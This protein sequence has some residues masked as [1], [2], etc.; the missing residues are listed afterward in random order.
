MTV[1]MRGEGQSVDR[2]F[3]TGG[4]VTGRRKR[5][6]V[7][8]LEC[9]RGWT[10]V[11]RRDSRAEQ[12]WREDGGIGMRSSGRGKQTRS[13]APRSHGLLQ[14]RPGW[15]FCARTREVKLFRAGRGAQQQSRR[16]TQLS[17]RKVKRRRGGGLRHAAPGRRGHSS[18]K[19]EEDAI[20][21]NC[22]FERPNCSRPREKKRSDGRNEGLWWVTGAG[23]KAEADEGKE[24]AQGPVGVLVCDWAAGAA[25]FGFAGARG[26]R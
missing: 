22:R 21:K 17:R 4:D 8:R 11:A 24:A 20:V 6:E 23:K 25:G 12:R 1:E 7:R 3:E 26:E 16:R 5:W 14:A 9:A 19:K 10:G 15:E 18:Q 2:R 13:F